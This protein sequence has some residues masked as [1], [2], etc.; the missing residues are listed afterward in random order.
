L[1]R[2]LALPGL[3]P[4]EIIDAELAVVAA[5]GF[6]HGREAERRAEPQL[7]SSPVSWPPFES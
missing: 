6:F 7:P 3:I 4:P 2:F 1:L 5:T